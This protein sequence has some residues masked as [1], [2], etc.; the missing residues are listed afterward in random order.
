MATAQ[1]QVIAEAPVQDFAALERIQKSLARTFNLDL[2]AHRSQLR[3]GGVCVCQAANLEAAEQSA[4]QVRSIG[5]SY[6]ILDPQG[7]VVRQGEGRRT[8]ESANVRNDPGTLLGVPPPGG[9]SGG[10]QRGGAAGPASAPG[11]P[12][13]PGKPGKPSMP[14]PIREPRPAATPAARPG[15][16]APAGGAPVSPRSPRPT[17]PALART[18]ATGAGAGAADEASS[19]DF[20][21]PSEP[22]LSAAASP[23]GTTGLDFTREDA[24]GGG[25]EGG[26]FNLDALDADNLVMLDGSSDAPEEPQRRPL[27][28]KPAAM[29][30]APPTDDENLELDEPVQSAKAVRPAAPTVPAL[31]SSRSGGRPARAAPPADETLETDA[32]PEL[33]E[34]PPLEGMMPTSTPMETEQGWSPPEDEALETAPAQRAEPP[35]AEP[36]RPPGA[37]TTGTRPAVAAEPARPPGAR[38]TGTRPAVAAEPPRER[39]MTGRGVPAAR[40]EAPGRVLFGGYFR[41]RPRLRLLVG[42][43]LALGLGAIVPSCHARSAVAKRVQPL[44]EDLS[45]AKAHGA[46][47]S[48][49]PNYRS[50]EQIEEAIS[51]VKTRAGATSF[52][53]WLSLAGLLAFAWFRF[54]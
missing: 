8:I 43:A 53:I 42:F 11:K 4:Q 17:D 12:S 45:T 18:M 16:G 37:R 40:Y 9:W 22:E 27:G 19:L 54:A 39:R 35:P 6:R 26:G 50:P 49:L 52:I 5:A 41:A 7:R 25:A 13:T 28:T 48:R 46:V 30:F 38:T 36:V 14:V 32:P 47:L 33:E 15:S 24:H 21:P 29:A 3:Q 20:A 44:L 34:I 23:P 31:P 2:T 51:S 1:Y 10:P